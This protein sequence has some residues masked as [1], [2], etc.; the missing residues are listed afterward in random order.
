MESILYEGG[1]YFLDFVD[2]RTPKIAYASSIGVN[3]IPKKYN[4]LFKKY[5]RRFR[6]LALREKHGADLVSDI[7]GRDDVRT[8]V[9]PTLFIE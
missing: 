5:L 8:V 3:E 4:H 1:F 2:D 6:Y 7:T 9:D